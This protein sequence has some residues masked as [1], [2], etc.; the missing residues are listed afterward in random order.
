MRFAHNADYNVSIL[1]LKPEYQEQFDEEKAWA[2]YQHVSGLDYGFHN[3]LY[4]WLDV[5]N[6]NV[7]YFFHLFTLSALIDIYQLIR[8]QDVK[9]LFL[10]A[11]NMRLGT[12][13]NNIGEVWE[14]LYRRNMTFDELVT[15]VEK[16]GWQYSNGLNYVCSA[17]VTSVFRRAGLF[18]DLEINSTEFTPKD[19]YQLDFF[20]V[21]GNNV[22]RE[23]EGHT[24][25][26]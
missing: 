10:D 14:E 25:H 13:A 7:P 19:L 17:F 20:D 16:E 8:P 24:K 2:W 21:S 6:K 1:P 26:G 22:P 18:G 9:I 15:M 12:N 5:P 4:T 23:C 11:M 3:F